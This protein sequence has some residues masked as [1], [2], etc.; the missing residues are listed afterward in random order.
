MQEEYDSLIEN[1][2]WMLQDLPKGRKM[3]HS[4]WVYKVKL[5]ANVSVVCFKA[6]L[7][8]KGFT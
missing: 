1:D 3:V 7:V 4:K 6:W 8:A 2:T 5:A